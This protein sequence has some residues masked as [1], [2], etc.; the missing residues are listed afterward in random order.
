M[1]FVKAVHGSM[2][3]FPFLTGKRHKRIVDLPPVVKQ[4]MSPLEKF[5]VSINLIWMV[6]C[7]SFKVL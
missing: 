3:V 4:G 5:F 6:L 2:L 1:L 7:Q